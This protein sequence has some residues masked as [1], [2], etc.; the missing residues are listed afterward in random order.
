MRTGEDKTV[1][2]S[3]VIGSAKEAGLIKAEESEITSTRYARYVPF[4]A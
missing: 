3:Q 2:T 1:V 4:W